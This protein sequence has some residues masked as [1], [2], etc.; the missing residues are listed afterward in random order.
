M[1]FVVE[2]EVSLMKVHFLETHVHKRYSAAANP[3]ISTL[4]SHQQLISP[5]L[6]T[7]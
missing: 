4:N 5:H 6:H 7:F 1:A 3:A 2:S